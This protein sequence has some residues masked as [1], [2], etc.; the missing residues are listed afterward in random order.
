M[1]V[2]IPLMKALM[3]R[4]RRLGKSHAPG[5]TTSRSTGLQTAKRRPTR[6]TDARLRAP[7]ITLSMRA[8]VLS[9]MRGPHPMRRRSDVSADP[10]RLQS[11]GNRK[12]NALVGR[13]RTGRARG[14][15]G[16]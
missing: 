13:L 15:S 3:R 6:S 9:A 8:A 2:Q 14:V 7:R 16:W 12:A 11:S 5:I 1:P 10:P 4:K